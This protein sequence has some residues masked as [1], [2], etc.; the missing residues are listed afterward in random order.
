[1]D[2]TS[3]EG[4]FVTGNPAYGFAESKHPT[5]AKTLEY[6]VTQTN[7]VSAFGAKVIAQL[8]PRQRTKTS[9]FAVRSRS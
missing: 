2:L 5:T 6:C 4:E 8:T 3:L 7:E 1:M 9:T